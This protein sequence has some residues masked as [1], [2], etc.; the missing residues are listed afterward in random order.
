MFLVQ[1]FKLIADFVTEECNPTGT[2]TSYGSADEN[3]ELTKS[4]KRL[5]KSRKSDYIGD[6]VKIGDTITLSDDSSTNI[7]L[8]IMTQD[9]NNTLV[10]TECIDDIG[11]GPE[12]DEYLDVVTDPNDINLYNETIE[13][14]NGAIDVQQTDEEDEIDVVVIDQKEN[15]FPDVIVLE[16]VSDS[17]VEVIDVDTVDST[18]IQLAN[19]ATPTAPTVTTDA[20]DNLDNFDV[21]V[22]QG[23]QSGELI[24]KLY[25]K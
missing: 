2:N 9:E 24:L 1:H 12:N 4:K 6:M 18:M 15:G 14:I 7:N 23:K 3:D 8:T 11:T 13:E 19:C 16:D 17:D 25:I 5:K 10:T 20:F 22:I 21:K